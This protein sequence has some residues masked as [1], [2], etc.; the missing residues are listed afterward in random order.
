MCQRVCVRAYTREEIDPEFPLR[1]VSVSTRHPFSQSFSLLL[2]VRV[3]PHRRL[4]QTGEE[5]EE[6]QGGVWGR[7]AGREDGWGG[8]GG[9]EGAQTSP[10]RRRLLP[11]QPQG[12]PL[13]TGRRE[14]LRLLG[15]EVP[16]RRPLRS[17]PA[18]VSP[19]L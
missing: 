6:R 1:N 17:R 19:D 16:S 8:R 12:T 9:N 18:R 4:G 10:L 11:L 13:P 7:G 14:V 3:G 15:E 5:R 2:G